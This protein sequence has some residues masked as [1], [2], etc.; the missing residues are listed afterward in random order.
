MFALVWLVSQINWVQSAR[1]LL[2]L[3]LVTIAFVTCAT[4]GGIV[5]RFYTWH[6]LLRRIDRVSLRD[7]GWIDLTVN[8]IN[9]LFPSRLSGRSTA[10]LVIRRR[11]GI[12]WADAIAATGVHTALYALMYGV[13]AMIGLGLVHDRFSPEL[14][15]VLGL[16]V[17]LYL[18]SGLVLLT[19]GGHLFVLER[20]VNWIERLLRGI[21]IVGRAAGALFGRLP[22]FADDSATCFR[23]LVSNPGTLF[24]YGLGWTGVALVAPG[25][26]V[27]LLLDGF[28][29]PFSPAVLLPLYLLL[30]YSV[31][32]LPLTPGGIG[33]SE[34]TATLVFVSFGVPES[35]V[36]P[37][38]FLDRLLGV[39][40]PSLL[41]SIPTMRLDVF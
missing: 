11:T 36:V 29:A 6:V 8:F 27:L 17:L 41:G 20:L 24:K 1:L 33:I 2:D 37:V 15:I 32:L 5:A 13:V 16:S 35:V 28:G 3:N 22:E 4:L 19:A 12:S 23:Y 34:A 25:I 31:T 39:Y 10:P 7:S 14:R 38:I 9:Q 21:P 26:R 30:A 40:L 18:A